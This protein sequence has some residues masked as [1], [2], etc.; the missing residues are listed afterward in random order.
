MIGRAAAEVLNAL[1]AY[2]EAGDPRLVAPLAPGTVGGAAVTW[3]HEC[4]HSALAIVARQA[5]G[6]VWQAIEAAGRPYGI[7][8]VGQRG[9]ESLPP[10]GA[11]R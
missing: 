6:L 3:L 7:S 8:C 4:D 1:G 11:R 2:G 5:A 10:D 9:S